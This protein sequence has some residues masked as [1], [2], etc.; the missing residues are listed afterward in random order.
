MKHL[1]MQFSPNVN[2]HITFQPLHFTY[3]NMISIY[4]LLSILIFANLTNLQS[5][6]FS[7][8]SYDTQKN[9]LKYDIM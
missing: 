6:P 1:I 4:P 9:Y 7:L 5:I 8:P 2:V 3:R